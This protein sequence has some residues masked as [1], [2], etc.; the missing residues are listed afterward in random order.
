LH[1]DISQIAVYHLQIIYTWL[2]NI[3]HCTGIHQTRP[4]FV[5]WWVYW[6]VYVGRV[7]ME[8]AEPRILLCTRYF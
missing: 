3:S 7:I 4:S 5:G 6:T 2:G 1:A 8:L